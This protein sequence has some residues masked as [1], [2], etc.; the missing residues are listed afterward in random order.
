VIF[1]NALFQDLIVLIWIIILWGGIPTTMIMRGMAMARLAT[2]I[3]KTNTRRN[4]I[5]LA[6]GLA[7][8]LS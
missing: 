6:G 3:K 7:T 5:G 1:G 4:K 8:L 2:E